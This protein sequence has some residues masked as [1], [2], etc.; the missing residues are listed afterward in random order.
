MSKK[1]LCLVTGAVGSFNKG[2]PRLITYHA[3]SRER[4]IYPAFKPLIAFVAT[5]GEHCFITIDN[6]IQCTNS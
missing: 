6:H 4:Y 3:H 5:F 2:F 1:I